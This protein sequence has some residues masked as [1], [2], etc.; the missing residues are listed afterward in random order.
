MTRLHPPPTLSAA[1][2]HI[3]D[4]YEQCRALAQRHARS[5][6]LGMRLAPEPQRS[7][8]YAVYAW[9]RRA[10]DIADGSLPDAQR[11]AELE[12]L[13]EATRRAFAGSAHDP[14]LAALADA[15]ARFNI[16]KRCFDD[17]ITGLRGDIGPVRLRDHEELLQYCDRVAATVGLIC[18]SIWGYSD[19]RAQHLAVRRGRAFQM[20]NILRDIREDA[21]RDR[22]YLPQSAL[23]RHGLTLDD[24]LAWRRPDAAAALISELAD[25]AR[26]DYDES[27]ELET[28][29]G[30][31][32]IRP[33]TAMTRVYRSLLD[34]ILT[35]PALVV[36]PQRLRLSRARRLWIA[37][38]CIL[39][40][41]PVRRAEAT[42][43]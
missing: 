38:T 12:S 11:R 32:G 43:T 33:L 4:G 22:I 19:P 9:M 15:V 21:Q 27:A 18:I 36:S 13:H 37:A 5:F 34:R 24:L 40:P 23:Q 1:D 28:L 41:R 39:D 8:L 3:L 30:P 6:A 14:T 17:M 35:Q 10:D 29:I 25:G 42:Q 26:A 7:A 31:S 20:T 2:P 16:P